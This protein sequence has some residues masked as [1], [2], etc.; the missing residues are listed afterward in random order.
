MASK[1]PAKAG[2]AAGAKKAPPKATTTVGRKQ[3]AK[4]A[5]K[6]APAPP[7]PAKPAKAPAPKKAALGRLEKATPKRAAA[8]K[9]AARTPLGAEGPGVAAPPSRASTA[10]AEAPVAIAPAPPPTRPPPGPLPP[11]RADGTITLAHSPDADDAFMFYALSAGQVETED[12]RY[13]H[14][15]EDIQS[16]NEKAWRGVH[17]VTALSFH[18]W[19]YVRHAYVLLTCGASFGD[20]Y[21]PILVAKSLIRPS[22]VEGL[23]VAIPGEWTTAALLVRLWLGRSK[24]RLV[25]IPY[26]KI[27]LAVRSGMVRAGVVI[28]EAQLTYKDQGLVKV[29]DFGHWWSQET[30]GLPLPLGG[31]AVRR[32]LPRPIA[33]KIALDL[34]RSIA[35]ALG[36]REEA[37]T[38]A[39][40]YARGLARETADKFVGLY[41]NDLTLDYGERGR[42]AVAHLY[43]RAHAAGLLPEKVTPEFVEAE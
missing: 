20:G 41:V 29:V 2:A 31:N 28:H 8:A 19:P 10:V 3:V 15:L 33:L 43:D 17:D 21:G 5:A 24:V 36:H 32:D 22:E 23:T 6:P 13:E 34:K 30:E 35:Y 25:S 27:V 26:D 1:K 14:V 11:R 16:L 7:P 18:A 9:P 42:Q 37:L 38:H 4:P 12:R 40:K 39:M